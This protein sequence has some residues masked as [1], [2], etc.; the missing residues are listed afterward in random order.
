[1]N[2]IYIK[3]G[4]TEFSVEGESDFIAKEREYFWGNMSKIF[5][6]DF[7]DVTQTPV[8]TTFVNRENDAFSKTVQDTN[9]ERIEGKTPAS[10]FLQGKQFS[11]S[12]ELIMGVAYYLTY[13]KQMDIFN[14]A[15]IQK[16]IEEM[17]IPQPSNI[18][19]SIRSNIK[20]GWLQVVDGVKD[21]KKAYRIQEAGR[22]W[23]EQCKSQSELKKIKR[24][25]KL[26]KLLV[27]TS[28]FSKFSV[29]NLSLSQYC[30]PMRPKK[31][32]EQLLIVMYIFI[33]EKKIEFFSTAGLIA[34][35]KNVFHVSI[36]Q[37]KMRYA[38]HHGEWAYNSKMDKKEI[39]YTLSSGGVQE[40]EHL[41]ARYGTG[42]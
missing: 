11:N 42:K 5:Q 6:F 36:T 4:T 14:A 19:A 29:G 3:I 35:F 18:W 39:Y 33:K 40:A 20:R 17:Q 24:Y 16:V 7:G 15:D 28:D 9:P 22:Q 13:M 25:P 41:I 23:Y 38:L 8:K 34:L 21:G 10:M 37:R 2:K 31:F 32:R 26:E 1:M 30:D 27:G 12:T